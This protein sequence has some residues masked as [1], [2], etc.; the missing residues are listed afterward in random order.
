MLRSPD[1]GDARMHGRLPLCAYRPEVQ[2]N[3]VRANRNERDREWREQSRIMILALS[4]EMDLSTTISVCR[5]VCGLHCVRYL[6]G[7]R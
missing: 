2:Q 5:R 4:G 1:L 6:Q 3:A 7:P